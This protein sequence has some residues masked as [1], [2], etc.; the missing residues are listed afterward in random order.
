MEKGRIFAVRY[1][2]RYYS[3]FLL[4]S[5]LR[6]WLKKRYPVRENRIFCFLSPPIPPGYTNTI[7]FHLHKQ[8][9]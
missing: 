2:T 5:K 6:F 7:I 8:L 3:T 9:N 4:Y 1:K